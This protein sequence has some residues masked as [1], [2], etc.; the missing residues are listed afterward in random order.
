MISRDVPF[1]SRSAAVFGG[2][3]LA[4]AA[5]WPVMKIAIEHLE[6]TWLAATRFLVAVTI[7]V[8][9]LALAGTFRLPSRSELPLIIAVGTLQSYAG[10]WVT[11]RSRGALA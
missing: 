1:V 5:N 11:R 2:V 9:P 7:L 10:F 3:I 8:L 4:W 6:P